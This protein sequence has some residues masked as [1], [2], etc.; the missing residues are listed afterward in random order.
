MYKGSKVT[1][2][3]LEERRFL[4][5]SPGLQGYEGQPGNQ[6]GPMALSMVE[7]HTA[8]FG[9]SY[10]WAMSTLASGSVVPEPGSLALLGV[11][12][13]GLMSRRRRRA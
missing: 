11:G 13:L 1:I 3:S 10:T 9:E 7:L 4:S 5:V 2:E 6:G 12:A 8:M